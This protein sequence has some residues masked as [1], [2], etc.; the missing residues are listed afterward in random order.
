MQAHSERK[1]ARERERGVYVEFS[2]LSVSA[3]LTHRAP[4]RSVTAPAATRSLKKSFSA[5]T[6]CTTWMFI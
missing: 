6:S 4:V 3:M 5:L 2:E 1:K